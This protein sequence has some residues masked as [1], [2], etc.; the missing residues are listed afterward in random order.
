MLKGLPERTDGH[1]RQDFETIVHAFKYAIE[2]QPDKIA[3]RCGKDQ[4][5]YREYG[6]GASHAAGFLKTRRSNISDI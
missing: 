3:L 6:H 5:A 1:I 4:T 2:N